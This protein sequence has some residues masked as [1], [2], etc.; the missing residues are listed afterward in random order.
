MA[1]KRRLKKSIRH[2]IY[3]TINVG[4]AVAGASVIGYTISYVLVP[5]STTTVSAKEMTKALVAL[6]S[7]NTTDTK[8]I[9]EAVVEAYEIET[10]ESINI[11]KATV[12]MTYPSVVTAPNVSNATFEI[13]VNKENDTGSKE[14]TTKEIEN[15]VASEEYISQKEMANITEAEDTESVV[16]T[17]TNNNVIMVDNSD[18]NNT[19][20]GTEEVSE[21]VTNNKTKN[22][23]IST[24]ISLDEISKLEEV[25]S[26][27]SK[28]SATFTTV[29]NTDEIREKVEAVNTTIQLQSTNENVTDIQLKENEVTLA[30]YTKFTTS[31]YVA[32]VSAKSNPFPM[33]KTD[34]EVDTSTVGKYEVK[35]TVLDTSGESDTETLVVNVVKNN[36]QLE[37]ERREKV[38]Q[39]T[40][41]FIDLTNGKAWDMDGAYGDQCWDLW[42]KYVLSEGLDFDYGCA[43]DGYADFV[44]KKYEKSGASKYFA[45]IS[46]SD[47][48][49]GDWLFWDKGSSYPDS[50]VALLVKDNGDGTGLCLTQSRGNGT[51]LLNLNLD[52]L[53]GFRRIR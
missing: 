34:G 53:G 48:Q 51:R 20:S 50:H 41:E 33:Y 13:I 35:Y 25:A 9:K 29:E 12:M 38:A 4:R 47:I 11:D 18:I 22:D 31:D 27:N 43:P 46:K 15:N 37:N 49:N 19:T 44:Y 28:N 52:V 23:N 21:S 32:S 17:S 36:D 2:A 1:K 8:K 24:S 3:K 42:A 30:Q 10:G 45:K 5:V 14:T 7:G 39:A 16:D 6:K 26:E 40:Q